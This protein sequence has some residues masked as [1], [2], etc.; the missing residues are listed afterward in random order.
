MKYDCMM[1]IIKCIGGTQS[2]TYADVRQLTVCMLGLVVSL[3]GR[4]PLG[5]FDA[6][7][8]P[9]DTSSGWLFCR[10]IRQEVLLTHAK[11]MQRASVACTQ[12]ACLS[13]QPHVM[14]LHALPPRGVLLM[15]VVI[16]MDC[17]VCCT[18]FTLDLMDIAQVLH[19]V[20]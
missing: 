1:C 5:E 12:F 2:I 6:A 15:L 10:C 20:S 4:L 9:A 8:I 11:R 18:L 3:V 16:C 14:L 17:A 13:F 7:C 19:V